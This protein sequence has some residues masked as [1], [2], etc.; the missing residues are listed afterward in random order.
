MFEATEG[1]FDVVLLDHDKERYPEAY[2]AARDRVVPGG[3]LVADNAMKSTS[4]DF[5]DLLATL[6]GET[7]TLNDS[8]AGIAE[9]LTSIRNDEAFDT[10]VL[11]IGEGVAISRKRECRHSQTRRERRR[12]LGEMRGRCYSG[13]GRCTHRQR[14]ETVPR[15][16]PP[17]RAQPDL[18]CG[19]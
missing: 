7:P 9:Y 19:Q 8:T 13:R 12:R 18:E 14:A 4:I 17:G 6:E 16:S 1:E 15:P 5:D 2:R 3:I 10:T 11:S